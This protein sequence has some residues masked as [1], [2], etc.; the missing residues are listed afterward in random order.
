MRNKKELEARWGEIYRSYRD[1]ESK[2]KNFYLD[3]END[4]DYFYMATWS[5]HLAALGVFEYLLNGNVE[6]FRKY[7][8]DSIL[9]RQELFEHFEKGDPV[10]PNYVSLTGFWRMFY[11]LTTGDM[12]LSKN[13]ARYNG[14]R[15]KIEQEW[16]HPFAINFGYTLKYFIEETDEKTK[17]M[18]LEKL[19]VDCKT[20]P[21]FAFRGYVTVFE[22]MLE[23]DSEKANRGFK[24]IL[25]GHVEECKGKGN[26]YFKDSEEEDI[27]IWG[28]GMANLA[29]YSGLDVK[30]DHPLIPKELLVSKEA[31]SSQQ[32][33]NKLRIVS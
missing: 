7:L 17:R 19:G 32:N 22:A 4:E 23:Q 18:C 15:F 30:I 13:F 31:L 21:H 12:V 9:V 10:H 26:R 3:R 2:I 6:L 11:A 5:G 33:G 29:I 25:I 1:R 20:K 16:D 8:K 27:C 14:G 28:L 24:E